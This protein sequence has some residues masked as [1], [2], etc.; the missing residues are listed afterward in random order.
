MLILPETYLAR[1]QTLLGDE[2]DDFIQSLQRERHYGLRVNNLKITTEVFENQSPF[3][4]EKVQFTSNGFYYK[5]E[6]VPAKHPYYYAGLYYIQEPSAMTP[7]EL[8]PIEEGDKVLDLCAAPGGKST[9]LGAKLKGTGLL[10]SNDISASRAKAL[11]KN[12]ELFGIGNSL[13]TSESPERLATYFSDYFDKILVDA[14]CSGEGMFRKDP[15]IIKSWQPDSNEAYN[16]IQKQILPYAAAMLKP[17]GYML[18]STCTFAPEE[19]EQVIYHFLDEHDDFELVTLPDRDNFS[20]GQTHWAGGEAFDM[21]KAIRLWPHKIRG[22]G[23]FIALLHKKGHHQEMYKPY[24]SKTKEKVYE[25]YTAFEKAYL[26]CPFDR[27]RLE[28]IKD[29]LYYMPDDIP[30]L[31][32]LRILRSGLYIGEL[33]KNRFE[34]SQALA[35]W[36]KPDMFKQITCLSSSS[37]DVIRYLKG[38]TIRTDGDKGWHLV[39]VDGFS[40]G[41]G[42]KTNHMLKNKFQA[43]W[44]WM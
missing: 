42:K 5:K 41:F 8:F 10:V 19:N 18:Y 7:A 39:T 22:E 24:A 11:L 20:R 31:K 28:V 1:M 30:S 9:E 12:I 3:H 32:G 29:K 35:S 17:G 16:S 43:G 14:P 4:I 21:E 23:H 34:P 13:V 15:N 27:R 36:L 38:E 2:Y 25:D 37:E 44:R 33:R 26:T 40:L 6:D